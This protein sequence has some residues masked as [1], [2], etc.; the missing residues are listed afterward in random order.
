[1]SIMGL[2]RNARTKDGFIITFNVDVFRDRVRLFW[3]MTS[4]FSCPKS[5][6]RSI[7]PARYA[8]GALGVITQKVNKRHNICS[9]FL[10]PHLSPGIPVFWSPFPCSFSHHWS[11]SFPVTWSMSLF[12]QAVYYFS[13]LLVTCLVSIFHSPVSRSSGHICLVSFPPYQSPGFPVI[14]SLF[15]FPRFSGHLCNVS[16]PP[17]GLPVF[18]FSSHLFPVSLSPTG[19]L[20][21][22]FSGH[23]FNVSFPPP[24]S[25]SGHLIPVLF[26][27]TGL[28]VF[29]FS[30]HLFNVSFPLTGGGKRDSERATGQ[31]ADR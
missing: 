18:P 26:S 19:L 31:P 1:M 11:P 30:S 21:F 4:Y 14:L 16:F 13:S 27:P 3:F 22:R 2:Q 23:L 7:W 17:N 25:R 10:S 29:R 15:C 20:V 5:L 8:G 24:V 12:P 6:R 9:M 28:P